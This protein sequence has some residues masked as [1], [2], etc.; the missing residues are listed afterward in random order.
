MSDEAVTGV[1]PT[2][3][4]DRVPAFRHGGHFTVGVEEELMLVD[5]NGELPGAAC[6]ALG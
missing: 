6:G 1:V 4:R 3:A 5:A 2:T